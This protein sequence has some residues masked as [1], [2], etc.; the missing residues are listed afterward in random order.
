MYCAMWCHS[1]DPRA[2]VAG[3]E[4]SGTRAVHER[5]DAG[6]EH[7]GLPEYSGPPHGGEA[8]LCPGTS[9]GLGLLGLG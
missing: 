9:V 1:Q 3:H 4:V 8:E 7:V 2:W 6:S 5:P